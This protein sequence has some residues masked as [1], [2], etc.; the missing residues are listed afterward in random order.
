MGVI[1]I[2]RLRKEFRTRG[3]DTICAVDELDLEVPDGGVFAFLGPNG[4]GKT[5]TLRC[6]L[7]LMRPNSGEVR[8]LD[9]RVP[10]QLHEVISK[11]GSLLETPSFHPRFSGRENLRLLG[12]LNGMG[13]HDVDAALGRLGLQERSNDRVSTYSFG[14]RQRLGIAAA[15]L[16]DPAVM[17]LDEPTNGLDP[18]GIADMRTL[19][20][21]L[22]DEGRTIFVSSH[23]L[24]EIGSIADHVA[25]MSRGKCRYSGRMRDLL[26]AYDPGHLLLRIDDTRAAAEVL[27]ES[28]FEVQEEPGML[29]IAAAPSEAAK[30]GQRLA[31]RNLFPLELRSAAADLESVFLR[32]TAEDAGVAR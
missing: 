5:T 14:M 3:R 20:R 4:A 31:S 22:A 17:L 11:I 8:M 23:L 7:G 19:L 24:S 12:Q 26:S 16:K 15:L 21:T 28:G 25:I 2:A 18:G 32:L 1:E 27:T 13:N 6:L 9:A 10:T 30:V 29:R